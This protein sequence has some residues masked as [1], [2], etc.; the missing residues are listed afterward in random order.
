MLR[1]KN[2]FSVW[3]RTSNQDKPL[4][5]HIGEIS[6]AEVVYEFI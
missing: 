3:E 6:K 4:L 1:Y 5:D 2:D